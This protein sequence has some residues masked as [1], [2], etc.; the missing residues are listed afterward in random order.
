MPAMA[1]LFYL[2]FALALAAESSS[3]TVTGSKCP[4]TCNDN[5]TRWSRYA[6]IDELESC[7]KAL[8][9]ETNL[10]NEGSYAPVQA[11]ATTAK[12]DKPESPGPLL[13]LRQYLSFSGP[14]SKSAGSQKNPVSTEE[15]EKDIQILQ[16]SG[17]S[18]DIST[19]A[20]SIAADYLPSLSK[21]E[22]S[23]STPTA[24]ILFIKS[25]DTI[26]GLY[27][28]AQI[29]NDSAASIVR[30]FSKSA[31]VSKGASAQAAAQLCSE[32]GLP[33]QFFGLFVDASG[34]VLSVRDKLRGWKDGKCVKAEGATTETWKDVSVSMIPGEHI[35]VGTGHDNSTAKSSTQNKATAATAATC[36]YTQVQANDG[37]DAVSKRCGISIADLKKYNKAG[38]CDT[39]ALKVGQHV[40]CSAG[41]LPDFSPQ[42]N[43]DGSCKSYTIKMGDN[44]FDIAAANSMTQTQIEDRNKK[45]WAWAGCDDLI[46][47]NAICLSTGEQPM[48]PEIDNAVCGPQVP[49][50]KKPDNMDHLIDL[51]PCPLKACCNVWAQCGITADFCIP[52][53]ADTNAPGTAKPNTNGCIASCGMKIVNNDTPPKEFRKI[54]YY[55]SWQTDRPCLH[56]KP[57][58]I[59][60]NKY[61]HVVSWTLAPYLGRFKNLTDRSST[62]RLATLRP[63]MK[64][65]FPDIKI[66]I[67][68]SRL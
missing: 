27:A 49:G 16:W 29:E 20:L 18:G 39:N 58:Q 51:N 8:I 12:D 25:G 47:G 15:Q 24:S 6:S 17:K 14:S 60:T 34:D 59:D 55:E 41:S 53:P 33:T 54:A 9:F 1:W 62:L 10:Y 13:R 28:G 38:I 23:R 46:P 68:T 3:Y 36:K 57:S 11:C 45:T 4:S 66:P 63:T 7:D 2:F 56:M 32:D 67:M 61:T 44:C 30:R 50:T 19:A 43:P 37:C 5:L 52:A 48:P 31:V 22:D 35:P 40:C 42:P 26:A 21:S 64:S 65:M